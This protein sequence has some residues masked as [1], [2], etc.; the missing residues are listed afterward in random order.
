MP[1]EN[2]F[3]II[4]LCYLANQSFSIALPIP[5]GGGGGVQ[6]RCGEGRFC[7]V[8]FVFEVGLVPSV[9]FATVLSSIVFLIIVP[10]CLF[11][12]GSVAASSAIWRR[13]FGFGFC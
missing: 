7:S 10:Q 4:L 8:W 2:C 9:L 3:F 12:L 11:F 5:D 13:I 1:L 6:H